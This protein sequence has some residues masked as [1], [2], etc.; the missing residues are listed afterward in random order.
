V[1]KLVENPPP[2]LDAGLL[3]AV[4]GLDPATLTRDNVAGLAAS[5]GLD[6]DAAGGGMATVNA[7]LEAMPTATRERL[8]VEFLGLLYTPKGQH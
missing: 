1:A 7:L 3:A 2:P 8:L 6:L 4:E 5:A